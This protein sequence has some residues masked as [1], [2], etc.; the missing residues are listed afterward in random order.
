MELFKLR[1]NLYKYLIKNN[2]KFKNSLNSLNVFK[3][4][5]YITIIFFILIFLIGFEY[6]NLFII[7]FI[8]ILIILIYNIEKI[9]IKLDEILSNKSFQNYSSY[10]NTLNKIFNINYDNIN[11]INGIINNHES[12]SSVTKIEMTYGGV[13]Y[14]P[15]TEYTITI[16]QPAIAAI[17]E[18]PAKAEVKVTANIKALRNG[19][20][21]G[22]IYNLTSGSGI[23]NLDIIPTITFGPSAGT[24]IVPIA[25]ATFKYYVSNHLTMTNIKEYSLSYMNMYEN[26]K[27]KIGFIDN[28]LNEDIDEHINLIKK[29]NDLLKYI[30]VYDN[31]Y[32]FLKKFIILN[33]NKNEKLFKIFGNIPIQDF[34]EKMNDKTILINLE[35]LEKYKDN[36]NIKDKYS[37]FMNELEL[38][39][40]NFLENPNLNHNEKILKTIA[41]F[42]II[43]YY[44][45]I[46]I[47]IIFTILLHI[48]FIKLY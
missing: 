23:T 19:S 28:V 14:T 38:K 8:I 33:E 16:T 48:F 41:N 18:I 3:N 45:L 22:E 46:I 2:F 1:Y 25:P 32:E 26:I 43:F 12:S 35:N 11:D 44:L 24:S 27:K 37:K 36:N 42:D 30:D 29:E 20:L 7:F 10:Y 4:L 34:I 17:G 47:I 13:G 6:I 9:L 39:D 40:L 21:S 5:I 15:D 31:K